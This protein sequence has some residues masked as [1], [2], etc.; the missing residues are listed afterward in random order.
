[1][2]IPIEIFINTIENYVSN[3]SNGI[4]L[5]KKKKIPTQTIYKIPLCLYVCQNEDKYLVKESYG[6]R[7]HVFICYIYINLKGH[8]PIFRWPSW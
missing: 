7:G 6:V 5:K 3:F 4:S 8:L 2:S 1:M